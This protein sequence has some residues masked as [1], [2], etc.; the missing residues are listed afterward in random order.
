MHGSIQKIRTFGTFPL[1][2]NIAKILG[3]DSKNSL[4]DYAMDDFQ[5]IDTQ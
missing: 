5:E 2:A 1:I 4:P 3:N